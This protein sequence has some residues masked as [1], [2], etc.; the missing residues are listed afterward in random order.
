MPFKKTDQWVNLAL[1]R[2]MRYAAENGYDRIAWTS[3]KQ[4]ANRYDLSKQVDMIY[5]KKNDD[6]TYHIEATPVGSQPGS[7][8][9]WRNI[10]EED[11]EGVVGK[12]LAKK[13]IDTP[14]SDD[15]YGGF[16][17]KTGLDLKIGGSGMIAFYDQIVPKAAK[18]WVNRS[19]LR[20]R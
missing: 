15:T 12:D 20:L 18:S 17:A 14:E 9:I 2:M 7:D 19:G 10:K 11:L 4:Q 3:G 6:G 16:Y 1:R 8:L 5:H 13:I